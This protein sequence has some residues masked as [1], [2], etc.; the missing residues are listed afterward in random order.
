MK[1]TTIEIEN[2]LKKLNNWFLVSN[3]IEKKYVFKDFK[4]AMLFINKVALLAEEMNH[5]PEW[6]NVYN[7][8]N[9]RLSTHDISGI[10]EKDFELAE[11]IDSIS[12]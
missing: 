3:A 11:A 9:I 12:L 8:L 1:L 10:S 5:H 7:K 4:E 6:N 2:R